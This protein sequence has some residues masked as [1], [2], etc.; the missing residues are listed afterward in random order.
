MKRK[1]LSLVLAICLIAPCAFTLTACGESPQEEPFTESDFYELFS[2]D[3]FSIGISEFGTECVEWKDGYS[4]A[5]FDLIYVDDIIEKEMIYY[6]PAYHWSRDT[7]V[8]EVVDGET[9]Y[10]QWDVTTGDTIITADVYNDAIDAYNV[11]INKIK[12]NFDLFTYNNDRCEYELNA[13]GTEIAEAIDAVLDDLYI[14][15]KAYYILVN[16]NHAIFFTQAPARDKDGNIIER[17]EVFYYSTSLHLS[18][19][20][21][22]KTLDKAITNCIIKG[23][24]GADYGEYYF[25]ENAF[26][27]Y[28]PNLQDITRNDGYFC[29]DEGEDKY[30]QYRKDE[31]G[32]WYRSEMQ[33]EAYNNAYSQIYD[34]F[35]A[36]ALDGSKNWYTKSNDTIKMNVGSVSCTVG[37]IK[38]AYKDLKI[39]LEN[40]E[41]V[42]AS[43]KLDITMYGTT[44]NYS[45][46]LEAGGVDLQF[47][48]V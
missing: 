20:Y 15:N 23:G 24:E 19:Y 34:L 38:Y 25:E 27:V 14:A 36:N 30:Y 3:E 35:Y 43:W 46:T 45:Y 11:L 21:K 39:Q 8:K 44:F 22:T 29:Y 6:D 10:K 18:S 13:E 28:T 4:V 5:E 16:R 32:K 12:D 1:L 48:N 31:S 7:Y 37:S 47:P 33:A 42:S 2:K 26:R 40:D 9:V 17:N 41:I